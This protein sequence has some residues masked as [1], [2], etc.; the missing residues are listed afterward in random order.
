MMVYTCRKNNFKY[1][2]ILFFW[3]EKRV[4]TSQNEELLEKYLRQ[5]EKMVSA[6]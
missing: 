5:R 1:K 2:T 3:T 4:F 6:S